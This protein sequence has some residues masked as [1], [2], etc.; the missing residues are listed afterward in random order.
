MKRYLFGE[1]EA[2]HGSVLI[3]TDGAEKTT[4]LPVPEPRLMGATAMQKRT[5]DILRG[6]L[7]TTKMEEVVQLLERPHQKVIVFVGERNIRD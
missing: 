2:A 1:A 5:Q 6:P 7:T 4:T 3:G